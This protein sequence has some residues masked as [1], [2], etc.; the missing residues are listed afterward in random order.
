MKSNVTT[1]L[2]ILK[3]FLELLSYSHLF[4]FQLQFLLSISSPKTLR[5]DIVRFTSGKRF[6]NHRNIVPNNH[7]VLR[8]EIIFDSWTR[9]ATKF[10][11]PALS[12]PQ[13]RWSCQ[14]LWQASVSNAQLTLW[15]AVDLQHTVSGEGANITVKQCYVK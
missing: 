9:I 1:R 13:K 7:H 15:H 2:L 8:D 4:P 3:D 11:N 10:L 12:F 14:H 6:K 5:K